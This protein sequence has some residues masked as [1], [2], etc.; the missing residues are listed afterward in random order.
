MG[1][2]HQCPRPAAQIRGE[3]FKVGYIAE[4]Y[5]GCRGGFSLK[6]NLWSGDRQQKR[7]HHLSA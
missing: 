3:R 6:Y 7:D 5:G 4:T 1:Q 2:Q